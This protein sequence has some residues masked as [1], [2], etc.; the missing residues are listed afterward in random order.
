MIKALLGR[1]LEP[2]IGCGARSRRRPDGAVGGARRDQTLPFGAV[3]D[4]YCLHQGVPVGGAWLE[5]VRD[6]ER[7]VTSKR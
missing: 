1:L 7:Q 3:W 6:Y 5:E 2:A 4:R